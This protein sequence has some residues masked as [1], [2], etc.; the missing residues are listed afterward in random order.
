MVLG[1]T[2]EEVFTTLASEQSSYRELPQFW[3]QFQL[4]FRDEPRPPSRGPGDRVAHRDAGSGWRCG[5]S[6]RGQPFTVDS[7]G[8]DR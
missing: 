5:R 3:Y 1:M 6:L 8:R 2:N 4:K 7:H